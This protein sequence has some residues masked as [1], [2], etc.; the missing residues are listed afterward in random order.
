MK[1]ANVKLPALANIG[2]ADRFSDRSVR[3]P[4]ELVTSAVAPVTLTPPLT[5]L[6]LAVIAPLPALRL[7]VGDSQLPPFTVMSVVPVAT[8]EPRLIVPLAA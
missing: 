7:S 8:E 6:K 5:S 1:L 2:S 4:T 3:L